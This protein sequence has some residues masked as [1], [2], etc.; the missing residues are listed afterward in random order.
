MAFVL[1]EILTLFFSLPGFLL[2]I[3]LLSSNTYAGICKPATQHPNIKMRVEHNLA[4]SS[5]K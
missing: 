3:F 5:I 4:I 2:V 1:R